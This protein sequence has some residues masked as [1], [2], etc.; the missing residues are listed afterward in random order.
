M[1]PLG[2][3]PSQVVPL[4]S[5]FLA[6]PVDPSRAAWFATCKAANSPYAQQ[7]LAKERERRDAALTTA[8]RRLETALRDSIAPYVSRTCVPG[9]GR[10]YAWNRVVDYDTHEHVLEIDVVIYELESRADGPLLE[11]QALARDVEAALT[12]PVSE[13]VASPLKP[14]VD[15]AYLRFHNELLSL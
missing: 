4:I 15:E 11:R 3:M 8:L 12:G 14:L 1:T 13:F 5:A 10:W 2:A 6:D 9:G 7:Q